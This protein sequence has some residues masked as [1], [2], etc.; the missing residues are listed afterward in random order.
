MML[1]ADF[2]SNPIRGDIDSPEL[3]SRLIFFQVFKKKTLILKNLR[4]NFELHI[5][6]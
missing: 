2:N 6:L 1:E 3:V 4:Y 5:C